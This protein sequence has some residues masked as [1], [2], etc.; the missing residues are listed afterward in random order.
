MFTPSPYQ[1]AIFD[2]IEHGT[3]NLVV[4]AVAGA[5][6][7]TT[8]VQA[9]QLIKGKGLFLAFNK[10][11]ADELAGRLV[12]TP[13]VA[14]TIHSIGN[15]MLT[16]HLGKTKIDGNK[17]RKLAE[18]Y[19]KEEYPKL[20]TE[21]YMAAHK[22]LLKLTDMC[23]LTLTDP[24]D[25]SALDTMMF[26]FSI[27]N[28]EI[29]FAGVKTVI[30]RGVKQAQQQKLIDFTDMLFLPILWGLKP[31]QVP[32]V[33]ADEC[34]DFSKAQ[35]LIAM[36]TCEKGGRM[37]FVGDPRQSIMG[38]AGADSQSFYN[39]AKAT[40]AD[41]LPL[42]ICYR[43]PPN[44]L[45]LAQHIVPHIAPIEGRPDG[46][47][48]F[49]GEDKDNA[50]IIKLVK[51]GDIIISRVT[52]PLVSLCIKLIQNRI[53]ARVKGRDIGSD[54]ISLLEQV[55]KMFKVGFDFKK[56]VEYIEVY[57][58]KQV[59]M[60][61]QRKGS[62][63]R[64]QNLR[65][66]CEAISACA[67]AFNVS[68]FE[69][70]CEEIE[71]LFSDDREGVTLSTIHKTKGLEADR[72]F[73]IRTDKLP[74]RWEKQQEWEFEQELNLLYVALTRAKKEL[75]IMGD[76]I[77]VSPKEEKEEAIPASAP[78]MIIALPDLE[79]VAAIETA[80]ED[81]TDV[82][83]PE[84]VAAIQVLEVVPEP[85][86]LVLEPPK[87]VTPQPVLELAAP[88]SGQMVLFNAIPK[89][90]QYTNTCTVAELIAMLTRIKNE[91]GLLQQVQVNIQ[92]MI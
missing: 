35:L 38:F 73:I 82:S 26:H 11:I 18:Q 23:R 52:A 37:V 59:E 25:A 30:D 27:D 81:D 6:K 92:V 36:L 45:A 63:S 22:A 47:L 14:K 66:R 3:G 17:Y 49:H 42:S 53:P 57:E 79:P 83:E 64:I 90:T 67:E 78:K 29:A 10:H 28:N 76:G 68:T 84:P 71:G 9:A 51:E 61:S 48:E 62:E 12:G 72:V 19:L 8:L 5:G 55:R 40:K 34:Q 60:M 54:L 33:M 7:T 86:P 15:G 2:Y 56:M 87:P 80:V 39:I 85:T 32:F 16:K 24:Q 44:H 31:P 69:E 4:N 50:K 13:M 91:H 65:D 21:E 20:D 70:L 75:H 41:E 58:A 88:D 46:V 74:L 77:S 1:Q 89:T 43:C